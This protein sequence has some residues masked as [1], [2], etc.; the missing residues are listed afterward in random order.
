M[1]NLARTR[2]GDAFVDWLLSGPAGT[3]TA[4][5]RSVVERLERHLAPYAELPPWLP[6]APVLTD[7]FEIDADDGTLLINKVRAATGGDV[8]EPA[9]TGD[10]L[11]DAMLDLAVEAYGELLVRQD[12]SPGTLAAAGTRA[13]LRAREESRTAEGTP[14]RQKP[15]LRLTKATGL[16]EQ[17]S[18]EMLPAA[19]VVSAWQHARLDAAAPPLDAL[20]AWVP[21]TMEQ[22]RAALSGRRPAITAVVALRG[23]RFPPGTSVELPG[24]GRV[25]CARRDDHSFMVYESRRRFTGPAPGSDA[26]VAD[27]GSVIVEVPVPFA[28][29]INRPPDGPPPLTSARQL[30][31]AVDQ[32][33]LAF[34]LTATDRA[35]DV[36]QTWQHFID[37]VTRS[38]GISVSAPGTP[39]GE[40]VLLSADDVD[41][42][43]A[44]LRR[45]RAAQADNL[46]VAVSRLLR[47]VS[48]RSDPHDALV[49]T[50]I[51]WEALF[52]SQ[53]EA[54]F[55][56]STAMA[57]LLRSTL[58]ER[59]ELQ[60]EVRDLYSLRSNIVHGRAT[61]NDE[62]TT[63]A[64]RALEITV[65]VLRTLYRDQ[66]RLLGM[67]S[68]ART[69]TL[70]LE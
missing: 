37:P 63:G 59:V 70:L 29:T 24:G 9:R 42:W 36:T 62:V 57:R 31:A 5:Q 65:E 33:R 21:V 47:A 64:R 68:D 13:G 41:E 4:R 15:V 60:R 28:V 49:D 10:T 12:A 30:N 14:F 48:E 51:C 45:I 35:A 34:L 8:P 44:W 25:R 2:L 22:A 16:T 66:P 61:K 20:L 40:P 7:L 53:H 26:E 38:G 17:F 18:S 32:V 69:A 52:G 43:A 50:V 19:V 67:P 6:I 1:S 55:R 46:G 23:V 56:V 58:A 3:L 54:T 27:A 39:R 11:L